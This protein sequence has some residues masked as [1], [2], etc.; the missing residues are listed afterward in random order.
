MQNP[1]YIAKEFNNIF[2]SV[3]PKLEKEIPNTEKNLR[4]H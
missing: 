1:Q 4:K 3:G 2:T